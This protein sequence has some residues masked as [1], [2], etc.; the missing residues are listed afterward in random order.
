MEKRSTSKNTPN[1]PRTSGQNVRPPQKT[2]T[3]GRQPQ[4]NRR[5]SQNTG[6]VSVYPQQNRHPSQNTKSTNGH[7][8]QNRHSS[9]NRNSSHRNKPRKI[10]EPTSPKIRRRRTLIWYSCTIAVLLIICCILSVTLFFKIDN[11][12]VDGKTRYD[13]DEILK[14]CGVTTGENLILCDTETG[15]HEI[16][17]NFPYIGTVSIERKL[18]NTIIVHVEEAEPASII[19]SKG[20]YIILSAEGKILE[21]ADEKK[22]D[23]PILKGAKV[24]KAKLSSTVKYEDDSLQKV[25]QEVIE[26]INDHGIENVKEIDISNPANIRFTYNDRITVLIGT[27]EN[28]D[29]KL[30]TAILI[31]EKNLDTNAT[32]T[33]DVS[34]CNPDGGKSYFSPTTE[35]SSAA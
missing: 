31:I 16:Q 25:I 9:Q 11:I 21:I 1:R 2:G 32:G 10:K 30:K 8:A 12:V 34:L 35:N 13:N 3:A 23:V 19:E 5:P 22:Y 14:Y 6:T 15:V 20:S 28:I 26:A 18:F 27:P 24:K 4:Q 33:L 7:Q 17:E 29:Y